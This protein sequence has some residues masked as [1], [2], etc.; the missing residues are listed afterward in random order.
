MDKLLNLALSGVVTLAVGSGAIIGN[1]EAIS[2][3]VDLGINAED[4]KIVSQNLSGNGDE[5]NTPIE[6]DEYY[7]TD[8]DLHQE[9]SEDVIY[10]TESDTRRKTTVTTSVMAI[11]SED[12]ETVIV[13]GE[14][15]LLEDFFKE[16]TPSEDDIIPDLALEIATKELTEKYALKQEVMDRFTITPKFYSTYEDISSTPVW[17]VNFYPTKVEEFS[18]IGC[19]TAIIDSKTGEVLKTLTAA[20]GKG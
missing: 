17:W 16:E 5:I 6:G 14:R 19:Y 20:D 1:G 18:E 9:V 13:N 12:G 2:K 4:T 10:N 7:W 15:V 8:S 3:V 11:D